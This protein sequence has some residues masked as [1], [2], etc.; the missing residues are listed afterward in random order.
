MGLVEDPKYQMKAEGEAYP[1]LTDPAVSP[2]EWN[3]LQGQDFD[4]FDAFQGSGTIK[5]RGSEDVDILTH[6]IGDIP[7]APLTEDRRHE[8][9]FNGVGSNV[10]LSEAST[11][12]RDVYDAKSIQTVVPD[13]KVE[14]KIANA[15]V[16]FETR[17]LSVFMIFFLNSTYTPRTQVLAY[18]MG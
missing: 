9:F 4:V 17:F 12:I 8:S 10:D 14:N 7:D 13:D 3:I 18:F 1:D 16:V 6:S 5:G 15:Y 11:Q 2:D